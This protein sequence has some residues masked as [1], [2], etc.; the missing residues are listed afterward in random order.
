MIDWADRMSVRNARAVLANGEHVGRWIKEVYGID[1]Q[2]CAAGCHPLPARELDY[3]LRWEGQIRINGFTLPKPF[4]L[5][6]R[7][8]P[9]KRFEY[10][11]WALKSIVR[12]TKGVSLVI[13]GQETEYTDQLR[14]LVDG[15]GLAKAV[16]FVGLVSERISETC[17]NAAAYVYLTR[18]LRNGVL[19][20][21]PRDAG[22]CLEQWR[23]HRDRRREDWASG[24]PTTQRFADSLLGWSPARSWP[25]DSD[26]RA[27]R[28]DRCSHTS[29]MRTWPMPCCEPSIPQ[30]SPR[31]K[32]G[33][34][35]SG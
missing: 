21:W 25:S 4:I 26:G 15:L 35:R 23:P 5:T 31:L 20:R 8:S 14:Y 32:S 30:L 28:A 16:H 29:A 27:P 33:A 2:R 13:T 7:H 6:N 17:R 10:A 1:N 3:R 34:G 19:R 18:G 11:I 12:S 22:G 24:T 9:M